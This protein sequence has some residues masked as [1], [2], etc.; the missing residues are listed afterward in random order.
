MELL[1]VASGTSGVASTSTDGAGHTESVSESGLDGKLA[2]EDSVAFR[3]SAGKQKEQSG[4][5]LTFSS[6]VLS[7]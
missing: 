4:S 3:F 5:V 6:G 1:S 7:L 2:L